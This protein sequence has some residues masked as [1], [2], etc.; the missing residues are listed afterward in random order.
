MDGSAPARARDAATGG[1]GEGRAAADGIACSARAKVRGRGRG[2]N[3]RGIRCVAD[4]VC[5]RG[6][7][8][9]RERAV[10]GLLGV[11]NWAGIGDRVVLDLELRVD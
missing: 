10:Y 8:K 5:R 2:W 7:G 4:S 6:E 3:K 9:T 11:G 1:N